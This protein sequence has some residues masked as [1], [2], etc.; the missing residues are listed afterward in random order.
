MVIGSNSVDSYSWQVGVEDL[1]FAQDTLISEQF[2]QH[3]ELRMVAQKAALKELANSELR[4]LL[5]RNQSFECTAAK[6]G[7][8]GRRGEARL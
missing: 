4:C 5:A 1:Q 7:R 6:I 2:A 8:V 3:W